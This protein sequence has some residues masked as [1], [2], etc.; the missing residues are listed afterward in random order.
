MS[1]NELRLNYDM[2]RKMDSLVL[3]VMMASEHNIKVAPDISRAI[4]DLGVMLLG[5]IRRELNL[6]TAQMNDALFKFSAEL[7]TLVSM[8][9]TMMV[10][11]AAV[12]QER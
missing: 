4:D 10:A 1:P 9:R 8:S 7:N 11:G 12:Q 6:T 5:Q 2:E 3:C